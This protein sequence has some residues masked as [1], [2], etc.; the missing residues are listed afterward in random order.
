M[1]IPAILSEVPDLTP[2]VQYIASAGQTVYPYTFPITQDSDLV[3]VING[4]TQVTDSTYSVSGVGNDTGGNC[5]LNTGSTVGDIITLYRDVPIQRI[6]QIAQNSGFSSTAFNA[7]FN[8][9]YLIMQQL[10]DAIAF[11]LQIPNTNSPAP[12]TTLTPANYANKFQA[13]DAYGNPQPAALL[14]TALTQA[15]FDSFMASA[16]ITSYDSL[17]PVSALETAQSVVPT[18]LYQPYGSLLRYGADPSGVA[19]SDTA[20][21]NALKCNSDVFD[22]FPGGGT[23]LFNVGVQISNFPVTIRGQAKYVAGATVVNGTKFVLGSAAGANSSLLYIKAGAAAYGVNIREI[24]FTAQ[25]ATVGQ[26]FISA[27]DDLRYSCI[28]KCSF[29]G[30]ANAALNLIAISLNTTDVFTGDVV[31]RDNFF[32]ALEGGILLQGQCTTVK[33]YGNELYGH[34]GVNAVETFG[35]L[36]AGGSYTT[37]Q[38]TAVALTGGSGSGA[39]AD[40]IVGAGGGVTSVVIVAGGTGYVVS[41]SLSASAASIGA[42]GSGFHIA[43][44]TVGNQYGF[45]IQAVYPVTEPVISQNYFEGWTCGIYARGGTYLKQIGN[46]YGPNSNAW[47]WAYKTASR[48]WNQSIGETFAGAGAP[49]AGVNYPQDN[50]G[51]C[52]VLGG[53][54]QAYFDGTVLNA[55]EGFQELLRSYQ[56]GFPQAVA[57]SAGNFAG[58]G[59]LTWTVGSSGQTTYSYS[60]VGKTLT[61]WFSIS[62]TL[63]G[64]GNAALTIAIPGGFTCA[65]TVVNPCWC[66]SNGTI[67]IGYA[68]AVASA[69]VIDIY[70]SSAAGN[71]ATTG[72]G[73]VDGVITIPVN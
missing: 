41:D 3:V 17:Y 47:E 8:N 37:G 19:A 1:G 40:I 51:F 14:A 69:S 44:A 27:A 20:L 73:A 7:E 28:E 61:I 25:S 35:T 46:D 45:G 5:T 15:M 62:G 38:Y 43:V 29:V 56:A 52:Q 2:Y 13:Y 58:A 10:E 32:D 68:E 67:A 36:T 57:F 24:G 22:N 49:V 59:S 4:I 34:G 23:Y 60:V 54:T 66:S 11:C 26:T 12:V 21:A 42:G 30:A 31:I 63:S 48:L 33:I 39:L 72:T 53:P 65:K 50:T 16:T 9:I 70:N 71:W 18:N 55:G 64:S 6:T